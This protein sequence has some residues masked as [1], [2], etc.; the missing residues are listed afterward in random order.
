MTTLPAT[1]ASLSLAGTGLSALGTLAGG[2][3][4]MAAAQGASNEA[5]YQAAQS[6][7]NASSDIASAQRT[8]FNSQFKTSALISTANARAGASGVDAGSG[9][10]VENQGAIAQRGRYAAA[11]DLWNGQN[12]AAG[13]LN[14]AQADQ[15]QSTL[16]LIGGKEAQTA[17]MYSALGTLAGGG[18]SAYKIYNPNPAIAD[19]S[20]RSSAIAWIACWPVRPM[21][22][23]RPMMS[24]SLGSIVTMSGS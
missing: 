10:A 3:N 12:A 22:R 16:D 14:K 24:M 21:S 4:A 2:N 20:A 18:A 13:D 1:M 9:S 15:Y 5:Q 19:A 6:R 8:M 17:S 23:R 7:I 11:L